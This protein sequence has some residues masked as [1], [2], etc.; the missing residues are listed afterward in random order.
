MPNVIRNVRGDNPD[1]LHGL[2]P[3]YDEWTDSATTPFSDWQNPTTRNG[4]IQLQDIE[5]KLW[6]G[7][8]C[9]PVLGT[10][11]G[12][13][14]YDDGTYTNVEMKRKVDD[15]YTE[16][17][18]RDLYCDITVSGGAVTACTI[19][20]KGNGFTAGDVAVPVTT[21]LG[22]AGEGFEVEITSGD[23]SIGLIN[24]VNRAADPANSY[25]GWTFGVNRRDVNGKSTYDHGFWFFRQRRT[26]QNFRL[27]PFSGF[28]PTTNNGAN[29]YGSYTQSQE[30]P[31]GVLHGEDLRRS[32]GDLNMFFRVTASAEAGRR[33]FGMSWDS[34]GGSYDNNDHEWFLVELDRPS[35]NTYS[36][37]EECSRWVWMYWRKYYDDSSQSMHVPEDNTM[38]S[39]TTTSAA[40]AD[41]QSRTHGYNTVPYAVDSGYLA[42]GQA[43]YSYNHLAGFL[44]E[45][46]AIGAADSINDIYEEPDGTQWMKRGQR[47]WIKLD[48]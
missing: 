29:G 8:I 2:G 26:S 37:E 33:C 40:V 32:T 44:P 31:N 7:E 6:L 36:T 16:C 15:F 27:I 43:F 13:T 45:G 4:W 30:V 46:L 35:G 22:S 34:G 5:I 23:A 20:R 47:V 10:I 17:G 14:G 48:S 3:F 21:T 19:S 42:R 39:Y 41:P 11:T 28:N 12:G 9:N 1:G 38:F 25:V 18:G 24:D